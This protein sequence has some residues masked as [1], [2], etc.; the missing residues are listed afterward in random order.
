MYKL[1]PYSKK[2]ERLLTLGTL[3]QDIINTLFEQA[4]DDQ[5]EPVKLDLKYYIDVFSDECPSWFAIF[6]EKIEQAKQT[7]FY[8]YELNSYDPNLI[9][10][11]LTGMSNYDLET[12]QKCL[13]VLE[14]LDKPSTHPPFKSQFYKALLSLRKQVYKTNPDT[15]IKHYS[16]RPFF[17]AH[18]LNTIFEDYV[19]PYLHQLCSARILDGEKLIAVWTDVLT[20]IGRISHN[21]LNGEW[22]KQSPSDSI[23]IPKRVQLL[24]SYEVLTTVQY[25]ITE[26]KI[27]TGV[28][29]FLMALAHQQIGSP[30][31]H[32]F[33]RPED[34]I[35]ETNSVIVYD[36]D[37]EEY[38]PL[39]GSYKSYKREYDEEPD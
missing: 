12:Q 7:N 20:G 1:V 3:F 25:L 37:S 21:D 29:E 14:K 17:S 36:S 22:L 18:G 13:L 39:T 15:L 30:L 31:S 34:T 33:T 32:N 19:W 9:Q 11:Q 35:S 8:L 23:E 10:D 28:V 5:P 27:E 24:K 16:Q 4:V 26:A 2:A 38:E 6:L